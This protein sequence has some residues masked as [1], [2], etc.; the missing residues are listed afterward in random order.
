MLLKFS[1][2]NQLLQEIGMGTSMHDNV[3]SKTGSG[4]GSGSGSVS[5]VENL[6]LGDLGINLPLHKLD[7]IL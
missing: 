3:L 4:S 7:K 6:Y 5:G 2:R 1:K